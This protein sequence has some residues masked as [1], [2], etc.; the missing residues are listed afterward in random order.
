MDGFRTPEIGS[1]E[2]T[3]LK[4][5]EIMPIR[6]YV[7]GMSPVTKKEVLDFGKEP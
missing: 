5:S 7:A 2:S 6:E 3:S 4:F 1:L